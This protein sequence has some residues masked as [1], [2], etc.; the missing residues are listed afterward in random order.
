MEP[1]VVDDANKISGTP[2]PAMRRQ[3]SWASSLVSRVKGTTS[4]S[5]IEQNISKQLE[6]RTSSAT[7]ARLMRRAGEQ[8]ED[9][10]KDGHVDKRSGNGEEWHDRCAAAKHPWVAPACPP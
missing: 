2:S 4:E 10:V 7:W 6:R 1:V 9:Y 8:P 3:P 5:R